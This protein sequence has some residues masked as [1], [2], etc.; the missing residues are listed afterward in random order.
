MLRMQLLLVFCL[1]LFITSSLGVICSDTPISNESCAMVTPPISCT[2]YNYTIYDENQSVNEVGNL[3]IYADDLYYFNFSKEN[4]RFVITLCDSTYRE[5]YVNGDGEVITGSI[6]AILGVI[7][8]LL[9]IYYKVD[10]SIHPL[11]RTFILCFVIFLTMLVPRALFALTK[12]PFS[13][14]F[15]TYYVWFLRIFIVYLMGYFI[16]SIADYYGKTEVFKSFIK[17]N[18]G[19]RGG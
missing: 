17:G 11:F 18:F 3:S 15:A 13:S 2:V 8:I 9:F 14:D 1:L 10:D 7:A 4:G 6:L 12:T 16:W 5:V 19:K